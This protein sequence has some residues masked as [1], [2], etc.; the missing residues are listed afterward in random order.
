MRVDTAQSG[1]AMSSGE[2]AEEPSVTRT[3]LPPEIPRF[4]SLLNHLERC[5]HR[6]HSTHAGSCLHSFEGS[7]S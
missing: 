4:T 3:P 1:S 2:G 6:A 5:E 7:E